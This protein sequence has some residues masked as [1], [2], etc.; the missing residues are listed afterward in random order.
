[1]ANDKDN[2]DV[3]LDDETVTVDLSDG[4]EETGEKKEKKSLPR[5]RLSDKE[6]S[7][8]EPEVVAPEAAKPD[9][10][11]E[12]AKA[13]EAAQK[14]TE[15]ARA[16]AL[17]ERQRREAAERQLKE[18]AQEVDAARAVAESAQ[19]TLLEQGITAAKGDVEAFQEQLTVAYEAGDFKKVAEVQAKMSRAAAT[20]DRL[21]ATKEEL[22][23]AP[24]TKL[25]E[26]SPEPVQTYSPLEQYLSQLEPE[27][28]NW[29]R[30]HPE[31]APPQL[32]GN[33]ASN[34]RMMAGHYAALGQNIAPNTADYFR[35]IEEH[36]GHRA[37]ESAA[38]V[39]TKASEAP[40]KTAPRAQPSAPPSREVMSAKDGR[41][42]SPRSVTLSKEQQDMAKVSFPHLPDKEA[43]AQYARNLLELE[44]EGKM[45]RLT[46]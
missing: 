20:L 36:T 14:Q 37:P 34:A 21:E 7:E 27:A 44:A 46:H 3:E 17:A 40:A 38:A 22:A 23:T 24:K 6:E 11:A 9:V 15:A 32:G 43:F 13:L 35:V 33:Q 29:L 18:R 10:V 42:R 19:L 2:I 26:Y 31:C 1:M 45:G 4:A 5:V 39:V 30:A 8:D 41:V 25:P 16:T 12:A 28:Q